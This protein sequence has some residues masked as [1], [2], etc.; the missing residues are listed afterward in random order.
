MPG[1][2]S[3]R[4]P[5]ARWPPIRPTSPS[6]SPRCPSASGRSTTSWASSS[7][8]SPPS[9]SSGRCPSRATPSPTACSTAAPRWR[10][11]RPSARSA[12]RSTPPRPASSSVGVEINATHHRSRD[13]RHRHR[14]RDRDPR[15]A[16]RSRPYEVVIVDERGQRVCTVAHH[17]RAVPARRLHRQRRR[18]EPGASTRGRSRRARWT[19]ASPG[20]P[21]GLRRQAGPHGA[22]RRRPEGR[23]RS[24]CEPGHEAVGV[25]RARP[26]HGDLRDAGLLREGHGTLHQGP[27]DTV[28]PELGGDVRRE[29]LHGQLEVERGDGR[30]AQQDGAGRLAVVLGDRRDAPRAMRTRS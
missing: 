3:R 4:A 25:A 27:T 14:H 22:G 13:L 21:G 26:A 20:R 8:R 12:P 6:S 7:S 10:S 18:A 1:D 2:S 23:E 28:P 15:S 19:C 9:G 17:L 16:A 24:E 5:T 29:H 11:P 30:D